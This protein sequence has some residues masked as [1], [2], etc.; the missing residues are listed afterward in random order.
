MSFL[1]EMKESRRTLEIPY[2]EVLQEYA[3]D[4]N[5][6]ICIVEGQDDVV[7]Y[8]FKTKSFF[9]LKNIEV[10]YKEIGQYYEKGGKHNVLDLY[11]KIKGKT[12]SKKKILFFIDRDLSSFYEESYISDENIY[13]TDNYAIE[14]DLVSLNTFKLF[15]EKHLSINLSNRKEY[16]YHCFEEAYDYFCN[17]FIKIMGY[18]L[19]WKENEVDIIYYNN[20]KINH[21]IL[22]RE[23]SL[24]IKLSNLEIVDYIYKKCKVDNRIIDNEAITQYINN[25]ENNNGRQYIRGKY[26][27]SFFYSY[28]NHVSSSLKNEVYNYNCNINSK[29]MFFKTVVAC[30]DTPNSLREFIQDR[31]S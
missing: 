20:I 27:F 7:Y 26:L 23:Y 15:C 1:E 11:D 21:I 29:D 9:D 16:I 8:Q 3:P 5:K 31:V 14:N 6:V 10:H 19:Y 25:F 24:E 28:C 17:L 22:F 2:L 18:I 30:S 4:K 13:I 12:Y